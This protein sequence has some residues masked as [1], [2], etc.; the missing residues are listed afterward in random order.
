MTKRIGKEILVIGDPHATPKHNNDRF[1]WLGNFIVE[2]QPDII[3]NIGDMA[4]MDSLSSYD[5]GS[6][7]AE[8]NRYDHDIEA[9]IDAQERMDKPIREYNK[10][11]TKKKH[12]KKY[13]PK[14]VITL[15]NH[16]QRIIRASSQ[17][18]ALHGKL[19]IDDLQY[20][21]HGWDVYPFL[22][23]YIV[24]DIAFSHYATSGIMARPISGDN[25]AANLV[26]KGFH[27]T[28]VGHSHLRGY[29]ETTDT[30]RGR[31]FGLVAGCYF[32]F[33]DSYTTENHRNW[34][35]LVMLHEAQ[36]G[37]CEPAWYSMSYIK[38]RY[39]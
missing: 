22:N 24:N 17:D 33:D 10:V 9:V 15:G 34:R 3:V 25:A 7:H 30:A 35:G 27:S 13:N 19:S 32:D 37:S 18:P 20:K 31:L 11:M 28:V 2:K 29:F 21:E 1:E 12:L 8:G 5:K 16:E 39:S 38:Q 36:D 14:K 6:I 4:S 26:K 23:P